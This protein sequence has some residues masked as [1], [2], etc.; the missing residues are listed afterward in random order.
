MRALI[1]SVVCVG[2]A[3][4]VGNVAADDTT[5]QG[6]LTRAAQET[7]AQYNCAVSI[8]FANATATGE[9]VAGNTTLDNTGIPIT[10]DDKFVWGSLTKMLTGS[11]ILRNCLLYTSP[12]PRDRG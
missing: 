12:S 5:L 10:A 3:T 6:I 8:A 2:L 7:S 11:Q 4:L 1:S 9:G